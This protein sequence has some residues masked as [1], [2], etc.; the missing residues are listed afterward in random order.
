MATAYSTTFNGSTYGG[1]NAY[2]GTSRQLM[3]AIGV[4]WN[5]YEEGTAIEAGVDPC[6]SVTTTYDDSTKKLAWD[7]ANFNV[8]VKKGTTTS[9]TFSTVDHL[10]LYGTQDGAADPQLMVLLDNIAPDA[11]GSIDV[12][13]LCL[14]AG[15][16]RF[17]LKVVSKNS[18]QNKMSNAA[19]NYTSSG[20]GSTSGTNTAPVGALE[21]VVTNTAQT[22]L[23]GAG[24]AADQEDTAPVTKVEIRL[25]GTLLGNATLNLVR[26]DIAVAH[27]T[28]VNSGYSFNFTVP[29]LSNT[30]HTVTAT[31]YDS[32]GTLTIIG[33]STLD[34][35]QAAPTC[36]VA[37]SPTSGSVPLVVTAT[38]TCTDPN[39]DITQ[40]VI[41][42]G[43]GSN[44]QASSGTHTYTTAG[45]Y[46]IT[47]QATDA[48]NLTG[49]ASQV[50][51]VS[52][53]LSSSVTIVTPTDGST[54]YSP[55]R[56]YA[57]ATA[58]KP[59]ITDIQILVD[60]IL[61]Y[62]ATGTSTVDKYV[63]M[64][65]GQKHTITVTATDNDGAQF[66]STSA[67]FVPKR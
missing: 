52:P 32:A 46:T 10:T 14:P 12:S 44:V 4:T 57:T 30:I 24:W 25:D 39:G 33:T 5:D 20:S 31:A 58:A 26:N 45:T 1:S 21:S 34:L 51:T 8:T 59:P 2:F 64:S 53:V 43:D 15:T 60:G 11:T 3:M 9:L 50:I 47:A 37:A 36:T 19:G 16:W 6:T 62:E 28:W 41:D 7:I 56:V 61:V 22:S 49:S 40:T 23:S 48:T 55:V 29:K 67:I 54:A 42:W 66:S 27:P 13:T 65:K 17:Y 18:M 63:F 35:T 38:S